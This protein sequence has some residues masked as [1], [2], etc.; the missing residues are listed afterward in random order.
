MKARL[1]AAWC[2]VCLGASAARG[3]PNAP[4]EGG[5]ANEFACS[6]V[7]LL[8]HVSLG[9]FGSSRANDIWG[10]TDPI[11]GVE[12]AL[13]GVSVGTAVVDLSSPHHPVIVGTLPSSTSESVWRDIK[14]YADHAF[15]V[16]EAPGHGMQVLDLRQLASVTSPPVTFTSDAN[17]LEFGAAHNI[18]ID[19]DTGFAYVVGSATCSGGLHMIDL[20]DPANP[21]FAGCY[22]GD[23]YTHDTQCVVYAGPDVEH[24][25][26]EVC[27]S[28]N[29]DTVTIVDVTDKSNPLLLSRTGYDHEYTHQGWLTEDHRY[30]LLGDELDEVRNGHGSRTYVWDLSDLD[31]PFLVGHHTGVTAAIDHNQYVRGNHVFQANYR[32]GLR[33][34]RLGNLDLAEMGEVAYFDTAPEADNPNFAGAWGVYPFFDSG[35]VV[36]SD[37]DRGLFVLKPDLDAVLDC[38]D[39][40]DN[41]RDGLI[42]TDD[43]G[44]PFPSTFPE[45]PICDDGIDNDGDGLIDFD[46]PVCSLSWPYWEKT[47]GCGLGFELAFLLP[48]LTALRRRRSGWRT[49]AQPRRTLP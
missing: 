47:P 16:S 25:G 22:S 11:T 5:T 34:L 49:P 26:R 17:Y 4:C 33:I 37:I 32:S 30:F 43:P 28:S 7:E 19:E 24:R 40:L 20:V 9:F 18:A 27:F 15:I 35:I 39:G 21:S 42:D 41:D 29:L 36:V 2:V 44:C 8:A 38:E 10:W 45:D 31:A 6:N 46:D 23:G 14:V 3:H 12:Y 1:L 48:L 13:L